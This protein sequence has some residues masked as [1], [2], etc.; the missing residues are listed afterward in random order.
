LSVP[1]KKTKENTQDLEQWLWAAANIL[2]GPVDQ[3][4]FKAYIFPLLF[5]KRLS[6]VYD[7]EFVE[8][9]EIS[10]NDEQFAQMPDQHRFQIPNGAH[11][12]DVRATNTNVGAAIGHAMREI[13]R[14]NG[15]KLVQVFGDVQWTNKARLPDSLLRDLVEHFSGKNLSATAVPNDMLGDAYEYLI[16]RFADKSRKSAGEFFT[17]RSVVELMVNILD[18]KPGE[19]IYDPSCGSGG[20]LIETVKHVREEGG[21]PRLL[22]GRIFGQ[23]KN[24]NTAAIARMNLI[25]HGMEDFNIAC[26]DTLREPQFVQR[27]ALKTFD[28]VIANPPF[29]LKKWGE[30]LWESDRWGRNTAGTPPASN[31]D[32]AWVQHMLASMAPGTGRVAVVLPM[33][34]LFRGHSE[35]RIRSQVVAADLIDAVIELGPNLFYGAT[36]PASIVV[37]RAHKPKDRRGKVQ[38]INGSDLFRTGRN[39]NTLEPGHI[40]QIFN[41]YVENSDCDLFSRSVSLDEI[42]KNGSDLSPGKYVTKH[43]AEELP[44][45]DEAMATLRAAIE[46]VK[47]SEQQV[48]QLLGDRGLL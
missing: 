42:V 33:G 12:R 38:F 48:L 28:C 31:A 30:D 3:A 41:L 22:F 1:P 18:P 26:A 43:V 19:S 29:S 23:E 9:L 37:A 11:W 45:V 8:A 40:E 5:L 6:D 47:Q 36:I 35:A 17:P 39:Q 15:N 44:S 2:R 46:A 25:L 7:E 21:D 20:M 4:D 14:V 16:K 32:W 27:D 34:A 13:E 24:V 10:G